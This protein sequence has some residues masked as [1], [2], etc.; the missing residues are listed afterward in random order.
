MLVVGIMIGAFDKLWYLGA[1]SMSDSIWLEMDADLILYLFLPPL[2]FES[3]ASCDVHV[4]SRATVQIMTMAGPGVLVHIVMV[5]LVAFYIFPY[6]WTSDECITFAAMLSATDPVAVVALLKELG[7]PVSLGTIIEG[8]A[9]LNDGTA[10]VL[11]LLFLDRA[12]GNELS[13]GDIVFGIVYGCLVGALVGWALGLLMMWMM[14]FIF[15]EHVAQVL[16]TIVF[17]WFAFYLGDGVFQ[18]SGV[19]SVVVVGL[20]YARGAH[21]CVSEN[22]HHGIEAVWQAIGF[23]ANTI[24]FSFSGLLVHSALFPLF[25]NGDGDRSDSVDVVSVLAAADDDR[26][27]DGHLLLHAFVDNS[28]DDTFSPLPSDWGW[29]LLF[30]VL[31]NA[32]RF[33]THVFMFPVLRYTGYGYTLS[34]MLVST[35]G[36]LRGAV[37][38]ALGIAIVNNPEFD[39][40]SGEEMFF[41]IS[42]N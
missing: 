1:I 3:A 32:I 7:A 14:G 37:G 38:L 6:N 9:L 41:H 25:S 15:D 10:Y 29:L 17:C 40:R 22:A 23:A 24:V 2:I 20:C 33:L 42:G 26:V 13:V 36:G 35:H 30:W 28:E 27:D 19:I 16:L 34:D 18:S 21:S 11:F 4:W 8:E 39:L 5:A 31:L 12:I